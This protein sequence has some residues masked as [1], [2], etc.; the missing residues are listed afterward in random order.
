MS[1]R[2]SAE[3]SV[4]WWLCLRFPLR[5]DRVLGIKLPGKKAWSPTWIRVGCRLAVFLGNSWTV[6]SLNITFGTIQHDLKPGDWDRWLPGDQT[7]VAVTTPNSRHFVDLYPAICYWFIVESV[8]P[9]LTFKRT[10]WLWWHIQIN[11]KRW[12]IPCVLEYHTTWLSCHHVRCDS[13][14][15]K[16]T[17]GLGKCETSV[18]HRRSTLSII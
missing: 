13:F 6:G 15:G 18:F 7:G 16:S 9:A 10:W 3:C 1:A 8:I 11:T 2:W 4:L 5:A 12:F 14:H 17:G